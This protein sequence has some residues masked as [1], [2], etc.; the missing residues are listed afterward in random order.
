M[1]TLFI[2]A[3]TYVMSIAR[4]LQKSKQNFLGEKG[5]FCGTIFSVSPLDG[6]GENVY[7]RVKANGQYKKTEKRL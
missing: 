4:I 1:C 2:S 3:F 7:N 6:G 5:E